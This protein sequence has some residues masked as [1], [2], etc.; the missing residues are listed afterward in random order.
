MF[1]FLIRLTRKWRPT[2]SLGQRGED[3][4]TAHLKQKGYRI[5]GRNL[6]SP[7]GEVDILAQPPGLADTLVVVE[8]KTCAHKDGTGPRPEVRVHRGKQRKLAR[9]ALWLS[10]KQHWKNKIVRFDVIGVDLPSGGPPAIRHHI[11]A[12]ESDR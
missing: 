11:S 7:I 1:G 4:A 5:L 2:R 9:L 3:A 10:K 6:R 12:F 8:V